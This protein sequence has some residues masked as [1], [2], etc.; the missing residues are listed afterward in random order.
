[1]ADTLARP[2]FYRTAVLCFAAFALLLSAIGIYGIVSYTVAQRTHELGVRMALGTT[3]ARLRAGLLRQGLLPIAAGAIPGIAAAV[4][5]SRL[6]ESLVS[7]A[8]SA[9]VSAY[10]ASVLFIATIAAIGIWTATRPVARLDIVE[11]LR[12]E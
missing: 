1:M 6:L 8:K 5:S 2:Q 3:S 9:S 10:A 12:A 4:L 7:G 11:I